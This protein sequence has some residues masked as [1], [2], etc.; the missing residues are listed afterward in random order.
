MRRR[1]AHRGERPQEELRPSEKRTTRATP[2][3]AHQRERKRRVPKRGGGSGGQED[4]RVE[5]M[6]GVVAEK[7][8]TARKEERVP[9]RVTAV[10]AP[11]IGDVALHQHVDPRQQPRRERIERRPVWKIRRAAGRARK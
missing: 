8:D 5:D 9:G 3:V 6:R 1:I 7:P 11:V 10:D 4:G 2:A